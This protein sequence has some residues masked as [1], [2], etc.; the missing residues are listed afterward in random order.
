MKQSHLLAVIAVVVVAAGAAFALAYTP[1]PQAPSETPAD[2]SS[3]AVEPGEG[4]GTETLVEGKD[5]GNIAPDFTL[6]DA[7]GNDVSLSDFRG[8]IVFLNFWA[9]WCPFCVN[10][11]PDIQRAVDDAGDGVIALFVNRGESVETG[12]GYL[13]RELPIEITSPTVYDTDE[14]VFRVYGLGSFMPISYIIDEEGIIRDRK[15]GPITRGE[16]DQKL[17]ALA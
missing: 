2:A 14:S 17:A 9:S 10:E 4:S 5:V 6:K 11:M 8:K 7:E 12:Q 13:G 16:I 1:A 15:F 3:E